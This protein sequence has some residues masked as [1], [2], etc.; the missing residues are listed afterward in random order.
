M[1]IQKD[2]NEN[3]KQSYKQL[4]LYFYITTF[5]FYSLKKHTTIAQKLFSPDGN[6][7]LLLLWQEKGKNLK[8][9]KKYFCHI[10]YDKIQISTT[11]M[12]YCSE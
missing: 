7:Y 2:S 1:K 9:K 8:K 11:I 12:L 4:Y 10:K 6:Y 5:I 3:T